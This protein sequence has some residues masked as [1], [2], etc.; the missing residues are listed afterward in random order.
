MIAQVAEL[1]APVPDFPVVGFSL[2]CKTINVSNL[3][4]LHDGTAAS[5]TAFSLFSYL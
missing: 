3:A 4:Q 5:A 2:T 1:L